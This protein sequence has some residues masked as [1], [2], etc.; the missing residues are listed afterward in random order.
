MGT[1]VDTVLVD[2]AEEMDTDTATVVMAMAAVIVVEEVAMD[3]ETAT[4]TA[5]ATAM[6]TEDM[7][8]VV[9]TEDMVT[10]VVTV[11]AATVV[12]VTGTVVAMATVAAAEEEDVDTERSPGMVMLDIKRGTRYNICIYSRRFERVSRTNKYVYCPVP[13]LPT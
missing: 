6:A 12:M 11:M 3:E 4:E 13:S 8:T 10:V 2:T 7:V 9:V 1:A 5:M